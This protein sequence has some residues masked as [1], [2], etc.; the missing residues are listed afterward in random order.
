MANSVLKKEGFITTMW[1]TIAILAVLGIVLFFAEKHTSQKSSEIPPSE[2]PRNT[3]NGISNKSFAIIKASTD[4][5]HSTVKSALSIDTVE[6]YK[7]LRN[8]DYTRVDTIIFSSF[9]V[10]ALCIM[11]GEDRHSASEF[12]N[13]YVSSVIDLTS[14][15]F[16]LNT[17]IPT[18]FVNRYEFYDSIFAKKQGVDE[19]ISAVLEE[20][21]YV[22]QTDIIQN[23]LAPF[24]ESSPLPILGIDVSMQCSIEVRCYFKSLLN[25]VKDPLQKAIDAIQ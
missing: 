21:E 11:S 12:S 18:A 7:C 19:K 20:F 1:I 17:S 3:A 5:A 24:S 13:E 15:A 9:I 25:Y 2:I 23:E 4:L 22:I 8:S 14:N 6:F 16:S 10:R